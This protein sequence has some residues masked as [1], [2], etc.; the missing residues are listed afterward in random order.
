M[1]EICK[2][3]HLVRH[4][5]ENFNRASIALGRNRHYLTQQTS[6]TPMLIEKYKN[7]VGDK[8]FFDGFAFILQEREDIAMWRKARIKNEAEARRLKEEKAAER[9]AKRQARL[10]RPVL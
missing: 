10:N 2:F 4:I 8:N 3:R 5:G 9:R 1:S 6:I 7:I